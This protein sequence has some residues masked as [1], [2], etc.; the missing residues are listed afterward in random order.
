MPRQ[1]EID[2]SLVTEEKSMLMFEGMNS[3]D[4]SYQQNRPTNY[5]GSGK[6]PS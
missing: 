4:R 1:P 6:P 2:I 3:F 5:Q